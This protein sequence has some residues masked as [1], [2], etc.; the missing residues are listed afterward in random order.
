MLHFG[1]WVYGASMIT[2]FSCSLACHNYAWN[3]KYTRHW[4]SL[5]YTGISVMI[6]GSATPLLIHCQLY[7]ILICIWTLGVLG[8]FL[9]FLMVYRGHYT[10]SPCYR[11]VL[12]GRFLCMGWSVLFG[13]NTLGSCVP[14]AF[15]IL[16]IVGAAFYMGGVPIFL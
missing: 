15:M 7:A 1:F 11:A 13:W 10:V 4:S 9:D 16:H 3:W 14:L 2:M 12:I 5:D 8:S 6:A